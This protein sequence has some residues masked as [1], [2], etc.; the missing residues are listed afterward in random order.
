MCGSGHDLK[1][2]TDNCIVKRRRYLAD[3]TA[4]GLNR[5]SVLIRASRIIAVL[6]GCRSDGFG[7]GDS[8]SRIY[9][10]TIQLACAG[11]DI[12]GTSV[13]HRTKVCMIRSK[14]ILNAFQF[15]LGASRLIFFCQKFDGSIF[16]IP[17]CRNEISDLDRRFS[18]H[19]G[20]ALRSFHILKLAIH[21]FYR[22]VHCLCNKV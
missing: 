11:L 16:A 12:V 21:T 7:N 13:Y 18:G 10:K 14:Y 22:I 19:K 1:F 15:F 3:T 5:R 8:L 6:C 17:V 2:C 9:H 20:H 4:I